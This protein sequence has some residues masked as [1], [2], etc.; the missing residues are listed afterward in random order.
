M[1]AYILI[2]IYGVGVTKLKAVKLKSFLFMPTKQKSFCSIF[3]YLIPYLPACHL[4][5]LNRH[6]FRF[7]NHVHQSV[8]KQKKNILLIFFSSQLYVMKL[9][10]RLQ[11]GKCIKTS[12][13][14]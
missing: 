1:A 2:T 3:T 13:S 4:Y 9:R 7:Q 6:R 10:I 12:T 11:I 8:I 14:D 5:D